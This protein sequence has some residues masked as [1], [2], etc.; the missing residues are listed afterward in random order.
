[1][2]DQTLRGLL[3]GLG[4]EDLIDFVQLP[5]HLRKDPYIAEIYGLFCW[6]PPYIAQY[7]LGWWDGDAAT[8]LRLPPKE[9]ALRLVAALGGRDKVLALA[10]EAQ[11]KKRTRG[12]SNWS[13]ISGASI[14]P[15]PRRAGSSPTC[16]GPLPGGRPR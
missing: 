2:R 1:M 7:A 8:L 4:P 9:S 13:A 5:P 14:P 15:M 12:R 16:C 10:K 11:G 3:T 6:Y